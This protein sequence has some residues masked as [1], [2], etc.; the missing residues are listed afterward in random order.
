L[1]TVILGF[2]GLGSKAIAE[3]RRLN[4]DEDQTRVAVD[5]EYWRNVKRT[6]QP[7]L[8]L[9]PA[10][11]E[12]KAE[13]FPINT[14]LEDEREAQ[15]IGSHMYNDLTLKLVNSVSGLGVSNVLRISC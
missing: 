15:I 2:I 7:Q 10:I 13:L 14:D 9:S 1:E 6:S 4:K 11:D 3:W 8:L 5:R 12:E